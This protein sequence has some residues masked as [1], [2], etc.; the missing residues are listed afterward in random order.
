M[1][2]GPQSLLEASEESIAYLPAPVPFR[3]SEEDIP[4][5]AMATTDCKSVPPA[6]AELRTQLYARAI[7]DLLQEGVTMRWAHSGAQLADAFTKIMTT[8][9]LREKL[10]QGHYCLQ[11]EGAM[12]KGRS[13]K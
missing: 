11:D 4:S 9:F 3:E 2:V 1:A 6:C 5:K 7:K 12:L 10:S 8:Q 13:E